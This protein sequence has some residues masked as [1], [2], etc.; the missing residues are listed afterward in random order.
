MITIYT[1]TMDRCYW[2]YSGGLRC[3]NRESCVWIPSIVWKCRVHCCLNHKKSY[4][5]DTI[6]PFLQEYKNSCTNQHKHHI[7]ILNIPAL[8]GM[9]DVM[10][11][12][13]MGQ[14]LL[15]EHFEL[16]RNLVPFDAA[17]LQLENVVENMDGGV[18]IQ[19]LGGSPENQ[20][21][22]CHGLGVP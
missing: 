1:G 7:W 20:T 3:I 15:G 10:S 17:K 21:P 16:Q 12:H 6:V 14:W 5:K 19:L 8:F 13:C 9:S 18:E 22:R 11:W 2:I 4:N